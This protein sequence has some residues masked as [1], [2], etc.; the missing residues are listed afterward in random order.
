MRLAVDITQQVHIEVLQDGHCTQ[1][2][3][4]FMFKELLPPSRTLEGL[5]VD[6]HIITQILP[7][8]KFRN[9]GERTLQG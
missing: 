6:D 2:G 3:E 5:Y 4:T 7:Q 9:K 8:K 1:P